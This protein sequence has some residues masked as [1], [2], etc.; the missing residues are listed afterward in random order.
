MESGEASTKRFFYMRTNPRFETIQFLYILFI[1]LINFLFSCASVD[2]SYF[3]FSLS[4]GSEYNNDLNRL[5]GFSSG[6]LVTVFIRDHIPLKSE[7]VIL[8][9]RCL[10]HSLEDPYCFAKLSRCSI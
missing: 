5:F 10:N 9:H 7:A 2:V 3:V 8:L 4:N 1:L 6:L